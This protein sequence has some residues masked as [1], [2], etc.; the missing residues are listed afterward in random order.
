MCIRDR[1][2]L[3][4]NRPNVPDLGLPSAML[5]LC[6]NLA[7]LSGVCRFRT[8]CAW[9]SPAQ[10]VIQSCDNISHGVSKLFCQN[11]RSSLTPPM[12][13]SGMCYPSCGQLSTRS[14][15]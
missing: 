14:Y 6:L 11:Q 13:V 3:V 4:R 8:V 5:G 1:M 15:N 10:V 7:N 9:P 2:C 12:A